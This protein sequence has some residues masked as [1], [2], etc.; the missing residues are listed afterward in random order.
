M[1]TKIII[2]LAGLLFWNC[3]QKPDTEKS[4]EVEI[5]KEQKTLV[6][7]PPSMIELGSFA[8]IS[9]SN[10]SDINQYID[11]KQIDANQS[12][13]AIDMNEAV[14]LYKKMMKRE[15]A[16]FSPIFEIK[17]TNRV[18]LPIQ[19]VGFGGPIWAKVLV[20]RNTLEIKKIAFE[21]FAETDGYGAAMTQLPF[22]NE[23]IGTKI[24]LDKNTFTLQKNMEN[25]IDNGVLVDGISG[26]TMTSEAAIEM[27]NEGLKKYKGYLRP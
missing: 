1:K 14:S 18:I 6:V 9:L 19:G 22:L 15:K 24:N 27:V 13:T 10:K 16:T 11:F 23:F 3:K 25:R 7:V 4:K 5:L 2:L 8:D 20:D 12:V 26:A 21:H 17:N